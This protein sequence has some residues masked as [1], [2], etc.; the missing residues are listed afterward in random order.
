MTKDKIYEKY[1]FEVRFL[2]SLIAKGGNFNGK[3]IRGEVNKN[4]IDTNNDI[5]IKRPQM[6]N[7]KNNNNRHQTFELL[8]ENN[9]CLKCNTVMTGLNLLKNNSIS[10]AQSTLKTTPKLQEK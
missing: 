2:D 7:S 5:Q 1:Y 3:Q 6:D 8:Q 9:R 10:F 4:A